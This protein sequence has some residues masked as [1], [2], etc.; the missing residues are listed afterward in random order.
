MIKK[1][2]LFVVVFSTISIC[3]A[4]L[5]FNNFTTTNTGS[6]GLSCNWM[7]SIAQQSNGTMWFSTI[8]GICSF[9]GSSWIDHTETLG[10]DSTINT[11]IYHYPGFNTSQNYL[12][13]DNEDNVWI[14]DNETGELIKYNPPVSVRYPFPVG[15]GGIKSIICDSQDNIWLAAYIGGVVI[16]DGSQFT[17]YTV[18]DGLGNNHAGVVFQDSHDTIWVA[19][20]QFNSFFKFGYVH[21]LI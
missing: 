2:S 3:S 18:A 13:V 8:M 11:Y 15:F 16:F 4:Q 10:M 9:D 17:Q 1:I 5:Q 21:L 7:Y 14:A 12:C 19:G 20:L 6:N